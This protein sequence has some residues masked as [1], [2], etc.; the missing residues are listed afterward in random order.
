MKRKSLHYHH[1]QSNTPSSSFCV[2]DVVI[3]KS[4]TRN[5][6]NKYG[7]KRILEPSLPIY[8]HPQLLA[9]YALLFYTESLDCDPAIANSPI[10]RDP[11]LANTYLYELNSFYHIKLSRGNRENQQFQK[12]RSIEQE[13]NSFFVCCALQY[14]RKFCPSSTTTHYL[15]LELLLLLL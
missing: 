9:T 11:T 2:I 13:K 15:L 1:A 6:R 3:S 8:M 5:S 7:S 10:K 12:S 4:W 14:R